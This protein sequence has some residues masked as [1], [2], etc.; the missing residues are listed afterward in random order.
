ML[1]YVAVCCSV[2]Q[3]VTVLRLLHRREDV[4]F[5]GSF[6]MS[7]SQTSSLASMPAISVSL[8]LSLSCSLSFSLSLSLSFSGSLAL[9]LS[10]ACAHARALSFSLSCFRSLSCSRARA[11]SLYTRHSAQHHTRT[12]LQTHRK[13]ACEL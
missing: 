9:L 3:R 8:S 10:I 5:I 7:P 1:Q 6:R 2:L 4:S 12:C 13:K 11:L